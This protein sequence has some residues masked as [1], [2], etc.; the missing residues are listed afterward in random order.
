MKLSFFRVAAFTILFAVCSQNRGDPTA[1]GGGTGDLGGSLAGGKNGANLIVDEENKLVFSLDFLKEVHPSFLKAVSWTGMAPSWVTGIRILGNFHGYA[2][3][4]IST[5]LTE[6]TFDVNQCE[7]TYYDYSESGRIFFGG[8]ISFSGSFTRSGSRLTLSQLDYKKGGLAFA[9]S[10]SGN[11]LFN[12]F[13][14]F[15]DE[16]GTLIDFITA[17]DLVICFL[18]RQ[19]DL[20]ITSGSESLWFDPYYRPCNKDPTEDNP[21]IDFLKKSGL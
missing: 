13:R 10:Y 19:G 3:A 15:Y 20:L 8:K 9:G 17:P 11:I 6:T 16:A 4:S 2:I 18:P 12:N 1:P 5:T 14:V 7:I 21:T